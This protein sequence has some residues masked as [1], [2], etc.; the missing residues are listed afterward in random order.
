MKAFSL[1]L[2]AALAAITSSAYAQIS[3]PT[4]STAKVAYACQSGKKVTVTYGFNKQNLP[5][6]AAATIN[7]KK[8]TMPINLDRSDNVG[9]YFGSE[10]NYRLGT[11]YMDK[12]NYRKLSILVT[13]PKDELV[14]K[15]C[16]PR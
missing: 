16:T 15:N 14:F 3:N 13:S 11:D 4:V 12:K 10:K 6:Y 8:R 1:T 5:T 7:G 9:T 2:F